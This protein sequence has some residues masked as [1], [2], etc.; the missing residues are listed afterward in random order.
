MINL[1]LSR[2]VAPCFYAVHKAVMNHDYDIYRLKGGRGSTK[3]SFV[4]AEVYNL[5]LKYPFACA[6]VFMKE[7]T[8]LRDG[9]FSLYQ[10]VAMR[11][12]IYNYFHFSLSPMQITY[13]PTGQKILFFGLDNPRK[14]KGISTG[15]PNTYVA[16]SHWEEL[17]DFYGQQELAT[18]RQSLYRGGDLTWTFETYNPPRSVQ[19]W[20]NRDS[21]KDVPGRLVHH[22]DYRMIP[23]DWLGSSFYTEMRHTRWRSE[24]EYRWM[25]LGEQ[26][27][28]GGNVFNNIKEITITDEMINNFDNFYNGQ[29]WNYEKPAA[30]IR[31]HYDD[32]NSDIYLVGERYKSHSKYAIEARAIIESGWNDVTTILDSARGGEML[33]AFRQEGVLCNNMYKGR[34]GNLTKEFGLQWLQSR[35]NI[36]IDKDLTPNAYEEFISY[37]YQYDKKRDE[38]LDVPVKFNDHGIDALRYGMSPYYQWDNAS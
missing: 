28:N 18:A 26:I 8:R 13:K 10:E 34:V 27:G 15:N 17:D 19:N 31:A 36:Y 6:V 22:S 38:Y 25:Y 2:V 14:T 3:S 16:I 11:M 23:P 21:L 5:I 9:A 7:K 4:S 29:D 37:E 35:R 33:S 20:V 1:N 24:D 32:V 30:F 12:G